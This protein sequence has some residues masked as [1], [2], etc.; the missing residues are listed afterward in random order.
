MSLLEPFAQ[1]HRL[2]QREDAA[3]QPDPADRH[4]VGD[5]GVP[6][7][8]LGRRRS[9]AELAR[10][11]RSRSRAPKR[12]RSSRCVVMITKDQLFVQGELVAN[13]ADV[14]RPEGRC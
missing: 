1:E 14:A 6:A 4:H 13:I 2:H 10:A 9:R 3:A 11:S 7:R 12:S 5:G 8:V